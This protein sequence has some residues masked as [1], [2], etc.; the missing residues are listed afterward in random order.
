MNHEACDTDYEVRKRR[1]GNKA[2]HSML[3]N[4]SFNTSFSLVIVNLLCTHNLIR[5]EDYERFEQ[6]DQGSHLD[7]PMGR[8]VRKTQDVLVFSLLA[9][10]F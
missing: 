1:L 10:G 8:S 3:K 6:Y 2:N 5:F 4:A 9:T 7:S